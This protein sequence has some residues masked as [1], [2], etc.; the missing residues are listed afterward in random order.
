VAG[1]LAGAVVS[2]Q[3]TA[4]ALPAG[5]VKCYGIAAAGQNDCGSHAAGNVCAGQSRLDYDGRDWKAVKS[6][7][8]CAAEGGRLKPFEGRNPAKRA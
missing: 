5:E 2:A 4:H 8:A 1:A 3:A 6:A 7:A